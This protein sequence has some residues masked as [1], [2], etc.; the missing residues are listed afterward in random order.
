[1]QPQHKLYG[2]DHLRALAILMVFIYHYGILFDAPEWVIS[3]GK[4]GW[5]GVD[6]FFVLSGYLIAS[7]LFSKI[8]AGRKISFPEFFIKR[9]FRIIPAYLVVLALYVFL[10][11]FREREALAPLWKYLTF[12]Q[13]IGLDVARQGTFSHA[14]S[15][16]IEEQFYFVLP[17]LLIALVYYKAFKKS[18]WLLLLLF[19][20]G[21]AARIY[22]WYVPLAPYFNTDEF[23]IYWSKWIYYPTFSR[24]DGLLVG[25]SIAALLQFKPAVKEKLAPYGNWLLIASLVFFTS[26]FL[27]SA[28]QRSFT[29]S[30]F[31]FPL[32]DIGYGFVVLAAITPSCFLYKRGLKLTTSIAILSYA[33]YLIHK[34]TIH[35]S[36]QQFEKW[37]VETDS[38]LMLLLCIITT[39]LAA[40]L[41]RYSIEKPFLRIRDKLLAVKKAT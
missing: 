31:G 17:L 20:L 25:V 28:D 10:P 12:T 38:N 24:L 4:F 13:N 29:A 11:S 19:L 8:D 30:V 23:A 18:Y 33:I 35:L 37:G 26:A 34:I 22:A 15:L 21:F 9:F 3:V 27:L 7:Q 14:W 40:I 5:T 32:V 41:L 16:C 2:L 6:L 1:M 39:V 36:Q